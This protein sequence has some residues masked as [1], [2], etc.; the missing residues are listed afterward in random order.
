MNIIFVLAKGEVRIEVT[1]FYDELPI[2]LLII[3]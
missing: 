3:M 2:E 1:H